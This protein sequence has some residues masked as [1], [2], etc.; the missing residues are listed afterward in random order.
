MK[1]FSIESQT[2]RNRAAMFPH[3]VPLLLGEGTLGSPEVAPSPS[4]REGWGEGLQ[5]PVMAIP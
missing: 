3:P 5:R 2:C 4:E 1:R